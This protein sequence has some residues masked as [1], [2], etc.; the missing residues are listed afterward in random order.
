MVNFDKSPDARMSP[1]GSRSSWW[2]YLAVVSDPVELHDP[3]TVSHT[4]LHTFSSA[5]HDTASSRPCW[6]RSSLGQD[7]IDDAGGTTYMQLW[8]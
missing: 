4:V 3:A 1:L 8:K 7:Y 5:P 2:K 6:E